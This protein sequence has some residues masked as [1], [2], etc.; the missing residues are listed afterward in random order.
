MLLAVAVL[1]LLVVLA[2]QMVNTAS[3]IA[4]RG[5]VKMDGDSRARAIFDRMALDFRAIVKRSDIDYSFQKETG[6]DRMTFYSQA[7]GFYPEGVTGLTPKSPVS[8]VGYR[9]NHNRLERLGKALVWNGVTDSTPA[10]SG[11][12]RDTP[13]MVFLPLT[14]SSQWNPA[15]S[16]T[17]ADPDFQVLGRQVFRFEF[18]FLMKDG[19]FSTLF[20]RERS[21]AAVVTIAMLDNP[22]ALPALNLDDLAASLPDGDDPAVADRWS[23]AVETMIEKKRGSSTNIRVYQRFFQLGAQP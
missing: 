18:C 19:A 22:N 7:S 6:S 16:G 17:A 8:L 15:V 23:S 21:V 12:S 4:R 11:L 5:A 10:V 20:D 13:G 2:A 9:V 3:V 1:V 14:L